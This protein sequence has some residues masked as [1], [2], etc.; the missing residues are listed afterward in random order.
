M[1]KREPHAAA[2]EKALQV[3]RI[4]RCLREGLTR[5]PYTTTSNL[6]QQSDP[7]LLTHRSHSPAGFLPRSPSFPHRPVSRESCKL[8]T[9]AGE[10]SAR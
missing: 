4:N 3:S 6:R 8:L 7:S 10:E 5:G 9:S 2:R 1:I